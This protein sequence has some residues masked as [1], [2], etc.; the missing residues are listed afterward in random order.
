MKNIALIFAGGTGQRMNTQTK[1]KQF[2]ELHGKPIIVYT[3]NHFENHPEID[4]ILIV[5]VENWIDELKKMIK[6]YTFEKIMKIVSG[7][8]GADMSIY[9]GLKSLSEICKQDDIILIHDGVRPLINK[10]LI[11][12]NIAKVKKYGNAITVEAARESIVRLCENERVIDVPPRESMYTAKAPQSFKFGDIWPLYQRA[13]KEGVR[14]TDSAHLLSIYNVEM[15]TVESTPN[16]IK[17]TA[18]AD[19]YIYRA[20]Y[21]AMENQQILGI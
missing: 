9:N 16:N 4:G 3:L 20:L 15:H 11:S 12:A 17:I 14:T 19:Y 6:L 21:E 18:P 5:C 8:D 1:P 10:D 7:G 13:Q 2:L